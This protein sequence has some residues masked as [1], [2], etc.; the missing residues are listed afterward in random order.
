MAGQVKIRVR[1]RDLATPWFDYLLVSRKE[2]R[3]IVNG[4]G[5]R[6][7]RFLSSKSTPYIALIERAK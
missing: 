2:M 6:I 3:E 7:R 4:T 1:Y 5:W